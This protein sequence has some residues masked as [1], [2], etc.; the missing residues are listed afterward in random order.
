[1]H[2]TEVHVYGSV[3]FGLTFVIRFRFR[4]MDWQLWRF[5]RAEGLSTAARM[6]MLRTQAFFNSVAQVYR[7]AICC[8]LF[9][10]LI[11]DYGALRVCGPWTVKPGWPFV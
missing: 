6:E 8:L 5:T 1:M 4:C 9:C 7:P 3:N 2:R 10:S 11:C